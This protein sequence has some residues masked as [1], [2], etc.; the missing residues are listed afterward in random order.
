MNIYTLYR[1]TT[2]YTVAEPV[3]PDHVNLYKVHRKFGMY[4][5]RAPLAAL[6]FVEQVQCD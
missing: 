3:N 5:I 2:A 1:S 6:Q 4:V